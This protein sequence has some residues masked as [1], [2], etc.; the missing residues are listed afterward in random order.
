MALDSQTGK[1]IWDTKR[2]V[3]ISWSS[4][5]LAEIGGKLQLVL[6]ADPLVAG[7][8][9]ETGNELWSLECIMGEVGSSPAFSDGLVYAANEYARLVAVKPGPSASVIWENDEYLPEVP[10]P[11]ASE[12]LLF[13]VTNYG[14]VVCY[15]AKTGTKYWEQEFSH[16][17]FSSPVIADKKL[18]ISD[19]QWYNTHFKGSKTAELIGEPQLGE[20]ISATPAFSDGRIYIRGEENLYCIGQ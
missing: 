6:S 15:D 3:K 10:S 14:V 16:G 7:Y 4:P 9:I 8:D 20:R 11:V 19:L 1:T 18:Y 2:N 17:F 5:I 12:G 13:L